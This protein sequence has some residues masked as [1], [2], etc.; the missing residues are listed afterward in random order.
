MNTKGSNS[1]AKGV[2]VFQILSLEQNAQLLKAVLEQEQQE[3][4]EQLEQEP[5][6][7]LTAQQWS[8]ATG[9]RLQF[10]GIG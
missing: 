5:I 7:S 9:Y 4:Q 6:N 3:Q 1:P 2:E 10:V 8:L